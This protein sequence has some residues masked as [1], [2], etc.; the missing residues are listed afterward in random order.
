MTG[1]S[2][3]PAV[4]DAVREF[5]AGG[6]VDRVPGEVRQAWGGERDGVRHAQQG[7]Q[8]RGGEQVGGIECRE[9]DG[10]ERRDLR[11]GVCT[12]ASD[13]DGQFE[14]GGVRPVRES[15]DDAAVQWRGGGERQLPGEVGVRRRHVGVPQPAGLRTGGG[16]GGGGVAGVERGDGPPAQ[17]TGDLRQL[18][19]GRF[20]AGGE[21]P[22]LVG[23]PVGDRRQPGPRQSDG[24]QSRVSGGGEDPG[25]GL[26]DLRIGGRPVVVQLQNR[27]HPFQQTEGRPRL[28]RPRQVSGDLQQCRRGRRQADAALCCCGGPPGGVRRRSGGRQR[29]ERLGLHE[30]GQPAGLRQ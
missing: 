29:G 20:G 24:T 6:A 3:V 12:P 27:P 15:A 5:R 14:P 7:V 28:P 2:A 1:I 11:G 8:H 25:E 21:R 19:D 9:V 4:P 13:L 17:P 10:A 22:D 30:R 16:P 23:E 26:H 18:R